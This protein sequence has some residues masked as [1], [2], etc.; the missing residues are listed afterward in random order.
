MDLEPEVGEEGDLT[1]EMVFKAVLPWLT[2]AFQ[3]GAYDPYSA[4]QTRRAVDLV[5]FIGDMSNGTKEYD[6]SYPCALELTT[7]TLQDSREDGPWPL[8]GACSGARLGDRIC[9]DARLHPASAVQPCGAQCDAALCSPP[10]EAAPQ[11]PSLAAGLVRR[12]AGPG[13]SLRQLA[14]RPAGQDMG[15]RRRRDGSEGKLDFRATS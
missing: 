8:P 13:Q 4:R 10:N 1:V 5:E 14:E 9:D 7:G 12:G 11:P 3:N 2:K 15:G 6:V